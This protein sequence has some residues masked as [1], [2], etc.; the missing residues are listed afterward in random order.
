MLVKSVL[1][2]IRLYYLSLFRAPKKFIDLL[3][4][5]RCRFFWGVKEGDKGLIWVKWNN[6]LQNQSKGGLGVG[7]IM[8]KN[9]S[10]LAKWRWRFLKESNA[11]RVL[12]IKEIYGDSGGF[13]LNRGTGLKNGIWHGIIGDQFREVEI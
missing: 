5:I 11:L 7:S 4:S 13:E 12:V 1:G 10:L 8:S 6:V 3:E 9:L 2:S